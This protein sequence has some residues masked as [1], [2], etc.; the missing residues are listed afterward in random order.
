MLFH[1]PFTMPD[2]AWSPAVISAVVLTLPLLW[3]IPHFIGNHG[4]VF[5][6]CP[7]L[8]A[9]T[10]AFRANICLEGNILNILIIFSIFESFELN[11]WLSSMA[12]IFLRPHALPRLPA[13]HLLP[14][15]WM[16]A[17]LLSIC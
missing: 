7:A 3:P 5:P 8:A 6:A 15:S 13:Q 2:G 10:A 1:P 4:E 9:S 14:F 17:I 12:L 11:P 16:T